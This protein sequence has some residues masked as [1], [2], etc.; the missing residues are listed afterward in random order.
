M[1]NSKIALDNQE[2]ITEKTFDKKPMLRARESELVK[3]IEAIE[4]VAHTSDWQILRNFIFDGLVENLERRLKT[5]A[6]KEQ[7]NQP[8]INQLQ[9]Q[10]LLARKYSDLKKL[11]DVYRSGLLNV[12]QMLNNNLG[13]EPL[14][15][16]D[17]NEND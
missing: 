12:R 14:N 17:T 3:L 13:T 10:L 16:P 6:E 2:I 11:A 15:A 8:A 5:E 4:R 1:N 9:G 7:L